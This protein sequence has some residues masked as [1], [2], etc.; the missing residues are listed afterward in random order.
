MIYFSDAT[1]QFP[2]QNG[3]RSMFFDLLSGLPHGELF[4]YDPSRGETRSLLKG[5]YFANGVALSK[6]QDYILVNETFR[7]RV[8]RFWLKGPKAGTSDLFAEN[9]PGMVDGISTDSDGDYW[10]SIVAPRSGYMDYV[11]A[12]PKLKKLFSHLPHPIWGGFPH[13]GM[14]L[15]LNKSGEIVESLQDPTG[16]VWSVT[17]AV[18]WKNFLFVGSLRAGA[19]AKLELSDLPSTSSALKEPGASSAQ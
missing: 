16:R 4:A 7:Y 6:E 8:R 3:Y 9:L 15:K 5:L 18:P 10:V 19:I 14:V 2:K 13:Y 1:C 11:Q 12:R 17:N